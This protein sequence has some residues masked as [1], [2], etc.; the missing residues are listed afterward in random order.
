MTASAQIAREESTELVTAKHVLATKRRVEGGRTGVAR[1]H[2]ETG[3]LEA[4]A[5]LGN[6]VRRK[7]LRES[8]ASLLE[9]LR[10]L[11]QLY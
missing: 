7:D 2:S 5:D 8:R 1:L 3:I 11:L 9:C 6:R 4:S 10:L